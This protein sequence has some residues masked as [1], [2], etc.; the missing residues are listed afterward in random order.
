[1]KNFIVIILLVTSLISCESNDETNLKSTNLIG[2]WLQ[3]AS[4]GDIGNGSIFEVEI[5][6]GEE[7]A[8]FENGT[9]TSDRFAE[10]TT[11]T[12]FLEEGT[13]FLN[14][15]CQGFESEFENEDGFIT[16]GIELESD[17]FTISPTSGFI[18]IEACGERY[19]RR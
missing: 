13:L 17:S 14:Y 1:M 4:F 3:V 18:C 11:G 9:F 10:C 2:E 19:E 7:L 12:F 6:D 5:E 16:F 15:S 8:F